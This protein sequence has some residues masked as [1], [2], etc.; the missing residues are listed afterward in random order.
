MKKILLL[1]VLAFG[2]MA[3]NAQNNALDLSQTGGG[4]VVL[5]EGLNLTTNTFTLEAWIKPVG[6]QASA[7]GILFM[8]DG[9]NNGLVGLQF[10]ADQKLGYHWNGDFYDVSSETS[11]P[12]D[13]WSHVALVV[14]PTQATLYVNGATTVNTAE[15]VELSLTSTLGIGR[16]YPTYF[17]SHKTLRDFKGLV[18]EVRIWNSARTEQQ[19]LDNMNGELTAPVSETDLEAYYDFNQTSGAVLPD[20]KGD[21]DGTLQGLGDGAG[22]WVA[23][24]F[25]STGISKPIVDSTLEKIIPF[26]SNIKICSE[27]DN[28]TFCLYNLTGACVYKV[29][30]QGGES[31]VALNRFAGLFIGKL[32]QNGTVYTQKV[33][34]SNN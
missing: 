27:Y 13:Q 22:K 21:L 31:T 26:G 17:K 16:D 20:E 30:V 29:E 4:D 34:L 23:S 25:I 6:T 18:D 11:V 33:L 2:I 12:V 32:T 7:A 15:H 5:I 1:T 8:R 9:A 24:G 19:I 10:N 28:E 3:G 14:E